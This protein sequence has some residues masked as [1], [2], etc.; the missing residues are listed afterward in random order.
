MN[1]PPGGVERATS[2]RIDV[3]IKIGG[4]GALLDSIAAWRG[5]AS[6]MVVPG[7]GPFADLVRAEHSRLGLSESA[8]HRMAILAMDQYGLLL[9]DLASGALAVSS[10]DA[11]GAALRSGRLPIFLPSRSLLRRDPF[12][13][14][15]DVTSDS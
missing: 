14:S 2:V 3:V 15:W 11:I 4:M 5:R 13:P 9:S 12:D 1:G 6:I 7:G 8:A 10:L